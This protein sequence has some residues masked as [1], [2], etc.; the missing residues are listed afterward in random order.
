MKFVS[1]R[2]NMKDA[3]GAVQRAAG[4]NANLPILKNIIIQATDQGVSVAATNLEFAI[5]AIVSGKVIEGGRVTVPAG[6]IANLIGNLQSDRL[7]FESRGDNLE[8]KTDNYSATLQ[9]LPAEDFPVTP[10]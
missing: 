2:S 6:L 10:K 7:N 1:F 4:E 9:G 5:T 3:I 8:I